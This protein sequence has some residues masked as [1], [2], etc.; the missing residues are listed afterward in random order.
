MVIG[1][2]NIPNITSFKAKYDL[3]VGAHRHRPEASQITFEG[4]KSVA[5]QIKILWAASIVQ[6]GQNSLSGLNHG[7]ADA[8]AVALLIEALQTAMIEAPYQL[9]DCSVSIDTCQQLRTERSCVCF[10]LRGNDL[11]QR[12]PRRSTEDTKRAIGVFGEI[13]RAIRRTDFGTWNFRL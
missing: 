3:P 11:M 12:P 7:C 8:A 5:G 4:V 10:C 13:W 2:F 9:T 1:Q 6:H